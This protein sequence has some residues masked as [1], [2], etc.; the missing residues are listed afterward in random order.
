MVRNGVDAIR[1]F[2]G[3]D[4]RIR[5]H[6]GATFTGRLRTELLSNES[7]SVFIA[8]HSGEG[9]TIYIDQIAD[10]VP[11]ERPAVP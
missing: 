7:L 10:I 9:V 3:H 8:R 5:M 6:D 11:I 2:A 4:V 1:R